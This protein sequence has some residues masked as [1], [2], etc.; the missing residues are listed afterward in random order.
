LEIAAIKVVT[1][2]IPSSKVLDVGFILTRGFY[3]GPRTRF[4]AK[5]N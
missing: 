4:P 5:T 2:L 1:G 3:K